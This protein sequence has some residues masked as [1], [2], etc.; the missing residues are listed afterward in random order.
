MCYIFGFVPVIFILFP[1]S[2]VPIYNTSVCPIIFD[3]V[4]PAVGAKFLIRSTYVVGVAKRTGL[5]VYLKREIM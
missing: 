3:F 5:H 4:V 1:V 2:I